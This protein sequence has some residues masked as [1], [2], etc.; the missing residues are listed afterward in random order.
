MK[1]W[2]DQLIILLWVGLLIMINNYIGFGVPLRDSLGGV[3]LL[4]AITIVGMLITDF[5]PLKM[6]S[7]FWISL[8]AIL[9][10]SSLNPYGSL[11]DKQYL[12]K[13]NFLAISTAILAYAG[14]AVGKDLKLF[15]QLS[16][17]I[18]VV[19][20]AVYTGTFLGAAVI[21]EF[22]LRFTGKV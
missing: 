12:G 18:V 2:A 14:L 1:K 9:V 7:V 3:I 4:I 15:K 11:F 22:V 5:V 17:R 8:V 16:W 20:L 21:A 13:I 19:A 6:P 10:T